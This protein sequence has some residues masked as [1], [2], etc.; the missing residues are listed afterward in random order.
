MRL[1][2]ILAPNLTVQMLHVIKSSTVCLRADYFYFCTRVQRNSALM[3]VRTEHLFSFYNVFTLLAPIRV[4]ITAIRTSSSALCGGTDGPR[5]G[6]GRSA[7][8]RRGRV[9]SD[10]PDGP[11]VRK[12]GG[13]RWQRL[14]LAPGRDPIR[15]KRS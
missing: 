1:L 12:G 10:E 7:T 11:C 3:C 13:V 9:L 5:P 15:E 6:A 2:L 14:D 4:Q 8:W